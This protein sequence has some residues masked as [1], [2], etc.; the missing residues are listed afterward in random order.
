MDSVNRL[1]KEIS[2][3]SLTN[4]NI[5]SL[6][7]N[8]PINKDKP[9]KETKNILKKTTKLENFFIPEEKD[10]LFWAWYIFKFGLG[11]YTI[12]KSHNFTIEKSHKI[13]FIKKIRNTIFERKWKIKKNEVESNLANDSCLYLKSLES[14]LISDKI[15]LIF[16]NNKI[17]YENT[18]FPG[19]KTCIIKYFIDCEKYGIFVEKEEKMHEADYKNKL[20]VVED[21]IK[22]VKSISNF[23]AKELRDICTKL[24]INIMKS[25]T[26]IKTK[27]VLYQLLCEKII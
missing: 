26:K 19:N 21:Y 12:N 13:Q 10:S 24:N 8:I 2:L 17:Y 15:N 7:K 23:T 14:M 11:E 9:K 3:F 18:K 16:M 1:T 4:R 27:K 22:P 20:F 25:P 5:L 6:I